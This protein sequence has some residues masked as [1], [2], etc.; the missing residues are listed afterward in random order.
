MNSSALTQKEK[1]FIQN[2]CKKLIKK[3]FKIAVVGLGYVGLSNAILLAQ[4]NSVIGV[5]ISEERVGKLNQEISPISDPHMS[6]Y[7]C[8]KNL[9]LEATTD[10]EKAIV[11]SD[12]VIVSTPT[13]YDEKSNFFDTSSV[14]SV[15]KS[16]VRI[17]PKAVIVIK[18]TIPVG[19]IDR[20]KTELQTDSVIFSP[21]KE[22]PLISWVIPVQSKVS[23]FGNAVSVFISKNF[24]LPVESCAKS[25]DIN[26]PFIEYFFL[27]YKYILFYFIGSF[28]FFSR[29]LVINPRFNL[30]TLFIVFF[31][32]KPI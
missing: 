12:F 6:E 29:C 4:H 31:F 9:N 24:K 14:E 5:D 17:E 13:N 25:A 26:V 16:A 23:A 21:V 18:S 22:E 27:L 20:V 32:F 28:R 1:Y 15:I 8:S 30:S 3:K 7:L 19:F 11:N 10:L 2:S